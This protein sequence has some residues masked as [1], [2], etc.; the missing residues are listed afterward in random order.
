M[1]MELVVA[2]SV[3]ISDIHHTHN[4]RRTGGVVGRVS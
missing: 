3:G 2:M 1:V 4:T